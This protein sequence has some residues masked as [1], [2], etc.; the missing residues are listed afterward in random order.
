M[1]QVAPVFFHK[2]TRI[3]GL[4]PCFEDI[5]FAC[6]EQVSRKRHRF[7]TVICVAVCIGDLRKALIREKYG[8]EIFHT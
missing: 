8:R 1:S 3:A 6:T 2:Y 5:F 4:Q 7:G